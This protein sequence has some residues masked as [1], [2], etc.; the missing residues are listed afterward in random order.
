M[1]GWCKRA[2]EGWKDGVRGWKVPIRV[3]TDGVGVC[4]SILLHLSDLPSSPLGSK[5]RASSA[6]GLPMTW[7]PSDNWINTYATLNECKR[8]P[9]CAS[10]LPEV[11]DGDEEEDAFWTIS[12]ISMLEPSIRGNTSSSCIALKA[13]DAHASCVL[14]LDSKHV[15]V[16]D[17]GGWISE[18]QD[19][20]VADIRD[21]FSFWD[22]RDAIWISNISFS[23]C[24]HEPGEDFAAWSNRWWSIK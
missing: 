21:A 23:L 19:E 20:L 8:L 14:W 6:V 5:G 17:G 12:L 3:W 9:S 10:I 1:Q 22:I 15:T 24:L 2:N 18:E 13:I 7:N 11:T 16:D 4:K